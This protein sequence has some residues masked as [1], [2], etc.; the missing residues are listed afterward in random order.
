[1][2]R[3]KNVIRWH[4]RKGILKDLHKKNLTGPVRAALVALVKKP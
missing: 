3:A 4:K 2:I 1:M